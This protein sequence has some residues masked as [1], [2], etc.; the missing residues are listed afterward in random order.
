MREAQQRRDAALRRLRLAN[1]GG[2]AASVAG[3]VVVIGLAHQA[4]PVAKT[5]RV[6]TEVITQTVTP[7]NYVTAPPAPHHRGGTHSITPAAAPTSASSSQS[8]QAT[9]QTTVA[10]QPSPAAQAPASVASA[11]PAAPPVTSG[12]S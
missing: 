5:R 3:A 1:R 6:A 2:V 10:Q 11:P 7:R 8:S 12:G 9:P 4:T